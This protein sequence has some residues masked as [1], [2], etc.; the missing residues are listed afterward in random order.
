MTTTPIYENTINPGPDVYYQQQFMNVMETHITWL[1]N[2]RTTR[3]TRVK[4]NIALRYQG[5]FYGLL[6]A[7]KVAP[8][9]WWIFMRVNGLTS[10]LKYDHSL[11][12]IML[13]DPQRIIDIQRLYKTLEKID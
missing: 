7:L 3:L 12:L 8:Q 6:R 11:V 2:H 4:D 1:K 9:Y 5:D 10:P 13:P